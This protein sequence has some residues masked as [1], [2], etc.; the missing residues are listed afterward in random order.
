MTTKKPPRLTGVY[1]PAL[2]EPELTP[3][4]TAAAL[5]RAAAAKRALRHYLELVQQ[6]PEVVEVRRSSDDLLCTVISADPLDDQQPSYQVFDAQSALIL[7]FDDQ[8]FDFRL[9]NYQSLTMQHPDQHIAGYGDLVWR[10][11]SDD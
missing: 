3:A 8:P 2:D 10:R 11:K 5:Q 9:L 4:E 7:A 6:I 1:D